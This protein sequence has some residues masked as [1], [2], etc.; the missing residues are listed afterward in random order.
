MAAA[1]ALGGG[2]EACSAKRGQQKPPKLKPPGS[3]PRAPAR[4]GRRLNWRGGT[5][6]RCAH[7]TAGWSISGVE[8]P[9]AQPQAALGVPPSEGPQGVSSDQCMPGSSR[10][11]F[12]SRAA[13]GLMR[14]TPPAGR[15]A[16]PRVF[17]SS[18]AKIRCPAPW[19]A[20]VHHQSQSK[21]S[22]SGDYTRKGKFSLRLAPGAAQQPR[23]TQQN[24]QPPHSTQHSQAPSQPHLKLSTHKLLRAS[25][26][27]LAQLRQ[28]AM[29]RQVPQA[30]AARQGPPRA[31][32]ASAAARPAAAV[33]PAQTRNN[34]W[35]RASSQEQQQQTAGAAGSGALPSSSSRPLAAQP[36]AARP[37]L[38][39]AV[40]PAP[41][42]QPPPA[43]K[44]TPAARSA[45]AT[46]SKTKTVAVLSTG[47]GGGGQQRVLVY[48]KSK[49]GKSLRR[50]AVK[51]AAR[52]NLTWRNPATAAAAAAGG[53]GKQP[54]RAAPA[55][56]QLAAGAAGQA[57]AGAAVVKAVGGTCTV[58]LQGR[59]S[60]SKWHK[61]VRAAATTAATPAPARA[62]PA[63]AAA[64]KARRRSLS[65]GGSRKGG[66]GP[67][68]N[69]LLRLGSSVY[70]VPQGMPELRECRCGAVLV[71]SQASASIAA[72]HGA[73]Y[74]LCSNHI[75]A[76]AP[77]VVGRGRSK[78]LQRQRSQDP[79][80][81]AAQQ[82][83]QTHAAPVPPLPVAAM[84]TRRLGRFKLVS[85]TAAAA[86]SAARKLRAP[87]SRATSAAA[88]ALKARGGVVKATALAGSAVKK[89]A[90]RRQAAVAAADSRGGSGRGA[91]I[92]YCPLY[93]RT[94]KCERR[95]KGCPYK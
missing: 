60:G 19:M 77:Q 71:G 24:A 37:A 9:Q 80:A 57:R 12:V 22:G 90:W 85:V 55:A 65:L 62:Q 20:C 50:T 13:H 18:R 47:T 83:Q 87:S 10:A 78:S 59:R 46:A 41:A 45:A 33:A 7:L 76:L 70:K 31:A 26:T 74:T 39:T 4:A 94:G 92:V 28:Q 72:A 64:S 54:S 35:T 79:P 1:G 56:G 29:Q 8:A 82:Q 93:C 69:K 84:G 95:G 89:Q 25:P 75:N 16:A 6:Q 27:L 38:A 40:K 3:A 51:S 52:G 61:Y 42:G 91:A 44:P 30:A 88:A 11:L 81:G 43:A 2:R 36:V 34:S 53:G 32:A 58:A 5:L 21:M 23:S 14:I 63:A 15:A 67:G 17:V 66:R 73:L 48:Q 86:A 68:S 49:Q